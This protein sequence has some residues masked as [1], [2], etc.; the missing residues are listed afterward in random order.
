MCL[1]LLAH[2][3]HPEY[4]LILLVNR[5]EFYSRPTAPLAFWSEAPD[6]L[7]GRDLEAGGTWLGIDR[8]GY[9]AAITNYREPRQDRNTSRS[10]GLLVRDFLTGGHNP[11][12]FMDQLVETAASYRG[13]N[14]LAGDVS[15]PAEVSLHYF[16]NRG[17]DPMQV[18]PGVHGLSNHLLDTPWPKVRKGK[19][20]LATLLRA[21]GELSPDNL[22]DLMGDVTRPPDA[23]LPDTGVGL[24]LERLLSTAFISSARYGTRSTSLLTVRITGEVSFGERTYPGAVA[25][26]RAS[27]GAAATQE[28]P[29]ESRATAVN[30]AAADLGV[31]AAETRWERF[32]LPSKST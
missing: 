22:F 29:A 28:S 12:D 20:A 1:L 24:E 9:L 4:P 31:P 10:R 25:D 3:V 2:K 8:R 21:G 11:A 17:C 23:E 5:D 13:F 27:A 15:D 6:L 26:A 30:K 18:M 14:L 19:A 7:A 32:F 16:S